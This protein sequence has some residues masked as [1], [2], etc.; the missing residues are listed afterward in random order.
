M[1]RCCRSCARYAAQ[2]P[3]AE[4][5][6][7]RRER[8]RRARGASSRDSIITAEVRRGDMLWRRGWHGEERRGPCKR[9][10]TFGNRPVW[11]NSKKRT[12]E[13]ERKN[14][15]C[16][17]L[18]VHCLLCASKRVRPLR[19]VSSPTSPC[20]SQLYLYELFECSFAE[21]RV[22]AFSGLAVGTAV[23][24]FLSPGLYTGCLVPSSPLVGGRPS[25]HSA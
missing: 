15:T 25:F 19:W 18:R 11:S 3:A 12:C 13:I 10:G 2:R 1:A 24:A 9:T 23:G 21:A 14:V 8:R 5:T 16:V 7:R 22:S 20:L 4:T 6:G 17:K